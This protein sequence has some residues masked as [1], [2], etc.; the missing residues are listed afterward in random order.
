MMARRVWHWRQDGEIEA[1]MAF[2]RHGA[3]ATYQT[4]W[5]GPLA[6][7]CGVHQVMLWQAALALRDEGVRWLDLRTQPL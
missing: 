7:R 5:A 3:A 1:A 2:V 6:R 4:G